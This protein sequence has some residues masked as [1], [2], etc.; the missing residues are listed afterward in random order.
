MHTLL[1]IRLHPSEAISAEDFENYL[2]GLSVE[3]YE[4]S[5]DDPAGTSG[6]PFGTAAY[7]APVLPL[8]P[9]DDPIPDPNTRITQHY[10]IVHH[11]LHHHRNRFSVAT[12]VIGISN[13]PG[14]EYK[15][16]DVRLVITRGGSDIIHKQKYYNVPV[17]SAPIPADPNDYPGLAPSLHLALPAPGQQLNPT[18]TVP[19]DGT[20]PNF[21]NLRTAVEAVLSAEPGNLSDIADLT[22]AEARHVAYEITWDRDAFPL[23][24]PNRS[25][26]EM[27]TGPNSANSDQERDRQMFEGDLLIYYVKHNMEAERLSN[28]VFS[29]SAS[30]W[31]EQKSADATEVGYI[32]PVFPIAP[33]RSGKVNLVGV[34][35]AAL[36]PAFVVSAEYFYALTGVMPAQVGRQQRFDLA[37]L[38]SEAQSIAVIE[39]AID[40]NI[41]PEPMGVNRFQAARR[42]RAL[43]LIGDVGTPKC[44]VALASDVHTLVTDWLAFSDA[45]ID[46][47]WNVLTPAQTSGHLDIILCAITRAHQPLIDA[48]LPP[49]PDIGISNVNDL[50]TKT[51]QDWEDLL[52]PDPPQPGSTLLPD[53]TA[54]GTVEE[55][56][57]A[58]IRNLR[59]FFDVANVVDSPDDPLPT[60]LPML[61]RSPGNIVDALLAQYPDPAGFSFAGW[62]DSDLSA[63]LDNILPDDL[64]MKAQFTEW[65][66][67][68]R[69][70]I[71]LTVGILPEA[72]RFSVI[73][74][75]WAR[76]FL[77]AGDLDGLSLTRF[78][79]ALVGS[80]AYDYAQTLWN[81]A[82]AQ[83]EPVQ[84][85]PG[86]FT[87]VN[88]DGSLVNCIPPKH[89]SPLGPVAYLQ[90]IFKVSE[91]S[92]CENP[93]PQQGVS[94]RLV[95][96]LA[97]RRG[98]LGDDLLAT[99]SNLCVPLPLID[100]VNESL[101]HMVANN[102]ASGA[103]YNT[104][105]DEVGG[106]A[107]DT[108][109]TQSDHVYQHDA[110]TLF[111]ALPEHSTPATPTV[112]QT[113]WDE[114]RQ[115]FSACN[116]PYHQPLNIA[117]TY[118]KQLG[119]SRYATMRRFRKE[120]TEFVLDPANET[121]EFQSHLW[122]YPVRH[123]IALDYLC[124]TPEEYN[125]LY[126]PG[127][128]GPARLPSL[129]GFP[130]VNENNPN[131]NWIDIIVRLPEFLERTC[132]T[133]CEFIELWHSEYVE[134]R[135]GNIESGEF[136]ECEPCCIKEYVIV[137]PDLSNQNALKRLGV[138]IRL[139]R[140]LQTMPK[141]AYTFTELADIANVLELFNGTTANPEFIRQFAAF[142]ILRDD[143][144]L[145]LTDGSPPLGGVTVQE[146]MHLLAFWVPDASKWDWVKQHLLDQIQ[147]YAISTYGC[148]CRPP[149]FIKLLKDN[150]DP[151]SK[152]AG[153]DPDSPDDTWHVHPTH[154][155]RFAEILA[156]IYASDFQV[157][158]LLFLFTADPQLQGGDP[159]PL[160]TKNEALDLPFGSP[161]DEDEQSLFAL[162]ARLL[163][164]TVDEKVSMDWTWVRMGEVLQKEFGMPMPPASNRW[165]EL[166]K[167]FF[168]EILTEQG[169]AVTSQ[170]SMYRVSLLATSEAMW[171]TP[172]EGP[173]QYD[174]TA[175]ELWTK[176][177]V[178]DA[179]VIAKLAR[180]R[181][182]TFAE[183]SAVSDLYFQPRAE[184][185]FF[186]FLFDNQLEAEQRLIQEHDVSRRWAWFQYCFER[187]Y[188]RCHAIGAHLSDHLDTVTGDIKPDGKATA[189]LL[190]KN[191]LADENKALT[192]WEDDN[193]QVP[194]VTWAPPPNGN[195]FAALLG[196][197]GTGMLAEYTDTNAL[198]Q[199]RE[200]R[201]GI[202]AFGNSENASNTPIPTVIPA[203]DFSFSTEQLQYAAMRNGF[204]MANDDGEP[205]GGGEPFQLN[206]KG[207]LLIER[208]GMYG[209][210]AGAPTPGVETPDFEAI[211][212]FHRW[213][214][215]LQQGQKTWVLL[216]HD[217]LN[218]EAPADCAE[219]IKL[220]RGFYELHIEFER[221]PVFFD[222]PED[223][224]PQIT[225]FQLK[226][227][228]PDADSCWMAIPND[229]LFIKQKDAKLLDG[230]D[231]A[232]IGGGGGAVIPYLEDHYVSTVRD[233]RRTYQRVFKAM[234]F[235]DRLN[236]SAV[237]TA[238]DGQSEIDY[239]LSKPENFRGQSYYESG[240]NFITHKVNFNFNFL[241]VL[242]NYCTPEIAEDQRVAPTAQRTQALFDWWERLFDYTVMRAETARSPEL[243]VWLLFHEAAESH[244]DKPAHLVR[245]MGIDIQH[246]NLVLQHYDP[247]KGDLSYDV[248]SADLEDERWV[249]RVWRAEKWIRVL[250][251]N[252]L[253]KDITDARIFL[254]A[255]DGPEMDGLINLTTFYRDGCIENDEPRR[256]LEITQLNNS[257]RERGRAALLAYLTHMNRVPLPWGG[258]ATKAK[259][260]SELLL[261]DVE[262]GLCQK[263]SRIEEAISAFQLY[264]DRARLGLEADFVA[265]ADFVFAWDRH[266]ASFQV[267]QACKRRQIY[268]ENWI[269][270]SEVAKARESEAYQFLESELRR[271]DLTLPVPGGLT[272]WMNSGLP[273][274]SNLTL[275]Q[276]REPA[277]MSFVNLPVEGLGLLGTPDRHARLSWLAPLR[278]PGTPDSTTTNQPRVPG[279]TSD[280]DA[281]IPQNHANTEF[282]MW[283]QAAVRLGTKFIRI[284]A[285]GMPSGATNYM[286]KCNLSDSSLCCDICGKAH[287]ALVDE[288]YFW[289]EQSEHY[290]SR[291]Q[292]AEWG[293][294]PDNPQAGIIGDPQS[295]WHRPETL[296]GLL[297]W[298]S[299]PM[300]HLHWCRAHNGEFQ[301]PRKS[302]EGVP[303]ALAA[304]ADPQLQFSGRT[305]DS[306]SFVISGEVGPTGFPPAG[307][308]YDLAIDQTVTLP[309]VV[310]ASVPDPFGG[311]TAFPFFAW[312][313]PGAPLLPRDPF[314]AAVAVATHLAM[315]CR[316]EESL[317]WLEL[318]YK[319]L[320]ADNSWMNCTDG[321][322]EDGYPIG[323][324]APDT[325]LPFDPCCCPSDPISDQRAKQRLVMLLFVETLLNWVDALQ[326]KNTPE[327]FQRA[328]LLVDTACKIL[329]DTPKTVHATSQNDSPVSVLR[330]KPACAPLN[331]R[332]MCLYTKTR[333]RQELIHSCMNA[334]RLTNGI[335]NVDM[336][337]FGNDG[338]RE[339]W[340]L[341]K[342][343]CMQ[344][345]F[346]CK[347]DNPYRFLVLIQK[348]LELANEVKSLGSQLL[349]AYEKGDAEFLSQLRVLH[350]RQL[351]E[352]TLKIR[353]NQWREADWGVQSLQ[354][355]KEMSLTNLQY[356]RNLIASGLISGEAQYGPLTN[357][358][359]SL[360]AAGNVAEAIGQAM[361]LIP[362]PNVGTSNFVTLPPGEKLAMI[363]AAAGTIAATAADIINTQGSL[364][365]TKAGWN[366]REQ[367]WSHQVDVYTIEVEQ[368]ER[369]IL[370][371]ERR[372]DSALR[373]LNNHQQ[374][375]ENTAEIHDFLRDKFTNHAL[376]LWLQKETASLHHKMYEIA[377]HCAYQAEC[378]FNYERGYT[379]SKFIPR[380]SRDDLHEGLL[381]GER[382]NFALRQMEKAY[383]DQNVREYELTK[384][385]SLR[386]H[387]PE[388]FL[389]L[390][391]TGYCEI[392]IP[393]W[394]FDLDY[395]GHYMRR[396]KN[397]SVTIPCVVGPYTGVHCRLTLL[398]SVTRVSP[399][400]LDPAHVCCDEESIKNG[401][402]PLDEDVRIIKTYAVKEAISTT[403]SGQNDSGMF[404]LNF[405]DERYLPFEFA[406]TVSRWRIELPLENNHFDMESLSDFV[407]HLNFMA[408]EGGDN[409]RVA[410]R[411]CAREF[412]P[413]NGVR[414]L[415]AKRELSGSWRETS[416]RNS[417]ARFQQLGLKINR[418][419]FPFLTNNRS[420]AIN[421][422]ELLF[423]A[424]DAR[425]ST[426]HIVTFFARQN[427]NDL[428]P[429]KCKEDVY[430]IKCVGDAAWPG[431]YHGVLS[432]KFGEMRPD[433]YIDL[434]V[435][436]FPSEVK[437]ICNA[438]L[439]LGYEAVAGSGRCE[440]EL[441]K[442]NCPDNYRSS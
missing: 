274:H 322:A 111:E 437:K 266:F 435:L 78:Q 44:E 168:P 285:A 312:H 345:M 386:L 258:F 147:Q 422:L 172:F 17:E 382:L 51:N 77:K 344:E 347:P 201:G 108:N 378:A 410:A 80:V 372:R 304:G 395:P 257:L 387:F 203:M 100:I 246:S 256:Y 26:E 442:A 289:I 216:S 260:L 18:V 436:Q 9:A 107:L 357:T 29:L 398:S 254:W 53:F 295:D 194:A 349:A 86:E 317:K 241:P 54:P 391:N 338:I 20:A 23:P 393:E 133:Y 30:I 390:Q 152:L 45:D 175:Q 41:I 323:S 129:F 83:G 321:E 22:L 104:A 93:I 206:W 188:Q 166:G 140:K 13:P 302:S 61:E 59:R 12:A 401:Y 50:A 228:G 132:L 113:A 251:K 52:Q 412:V 307:F 64:Q 407:L 158:E 25:M 280:G 74:A 6:A 75:L 48:I 426:H 16:A 385:I 69:G 174:A 35:S 233:M 159:Y 38:D 272:H 298:E 244:Q 316:Y 310:A 237:P 122:R 283:F 149:E 95:L 151:L 173:F 240:I 200:V 109:P 115:D 148:T 130:A 63:T 28:Y 225:G 90:D 94:E 406:G 32:F 185:A 439:L 169:V 121:D 88:P 320:A 230:F 184:L 47:F 425:S 143:F 414:F 255:S 373:E 27:Y 394:M 324:T 144:D 71:A 14:G 5:F 96:L 403:S 252:F 160:Q 381:S 328:R 263:T 273:S 430:S 420:V 126:S 70:V 358:A 202:D 380:E 209:F 106:H 123:E 110:V 402:V 164:I 267:W 433:G 334:Q 292:V 336:P 339:C 343:V 114:I 351:N 359:M 270:W 418:S 424:P 264:I 176:I 102:A 127:Q 326:R 300:V 440:I 207:L 413:G 161:D 301:T 253:A 392:G 196:V 293:A 278:G 384:S 136:P 370:A 337:Y 162:R 396:I 306:L 429:D 180:I 364:G 366:R 374:V 171:N 189:M 404:E 178:T 294:I 353:Q 400:L 208:G 236:L 220:D 154:T 329:G 405:R 438:Y 56:T 434:G 227:D 186:S 181:Q 330:M 124:I 33:D 247:A 116:L 46:L 187:F 170:A 282:P 157:G 389:Q 286:P 97:S 105:A 145:A 231:T 415:D 311:L 39:Q 103:V 197:T 57:Q 199:W 284:A 191:I 60:E 224:C 375:M 98:P 248:S 192:P 369:D 137:F 419:M 177:A 190:L 360:R 87:P 250:N 142:Q 305:A 198:I 319:P 333:D 10:E 368:R 262:A 62:D 354:K 377:L 101:E 72:L 117:R 40:G 156:K 49:P 308:R 388:A 249:V 153:F 269:E 85:L 361:N 371:A 195:A 314:S 346:W 428:D 238:D 118:L 362:D 379:A 271:T 363:F 313:C 431:F 146:R 89:L 356:Y 215:V 408:R 221:L 367:E 125:V 219:A 397:I 138:F 155:L 182:L 318:I 416:K 73:E 165:Q 81:N 277:T 327:A 183:R 427:I 288:Y 76:G 82:Q 411:E 79:D 409:L 341:G 1:V 193:G 211:R 226:Y 348:A 139:W 229:K 234:L 281:N 242:D 150:L 309:E 91:T 37:I 68:I 275:L 355:S 287:P 331:P 299:Q 290:E 135:A 352:L 179:A 210:R 365:L 421:Q 119:T 417:D 243:P 315:H 65:L 163:S 99:S 214:V 66:I 212:R 11:D 15:T 261:I 441:G 276:K 335:A 340:K 291:E 21:A 279:T 350:E 205:L 296:P 223:V 36:D 235:V 120:I 239:M 376:Y 332:L 58:F 4:L 303:L 423:E 31:C 432:L 131:D 399:E 222:G 19:E 383:Y 232:F 3:V 24:N 128:L 112:A 42:L 84:E 245:H 167:H 204:A 43:S 297:H 342:D 8:D 7:I 67:C 268:R 2:D 213:R 259:H 217:W 34:G 55:R 141:T 218:E 265:L 134:F 92:T 325:S